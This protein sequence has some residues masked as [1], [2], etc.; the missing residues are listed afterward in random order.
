MG[1]GLPV[2]V[3]LAG[4]WMCAVRAQCDVLPSDLRG[5]PLWPFL[6]GMMCAEPTMR[7]DCASA[8]ATCG[9]GMSFVTERANFYTS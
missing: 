9:S 2:V 6:N 8:V 3:V 5:W 7:F 4:V 1:A